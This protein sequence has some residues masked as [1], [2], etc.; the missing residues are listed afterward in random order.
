MGGYLGY[1]R[2]LN[3]VGFFSRA[4]A[5]HSLR[6]QITMTY[7]ELE[8]AL[9]SAFELCATT[10]SALTS[11]QKQILLQVMSALVEEVSILPKSKPDNSDADDAGNDSAGACNPLDE[12]TLAQRQALLE[13]VQEQEQQGRSWKVQLLNDWLA[14]VD[15]GPVQF[16]RESYG[17]KWLDQVAPIHVAQYVETAVTLEVGDRI[18]ISNSLWEW[19][20]DTGP[21]SREWFV[22]TV[23]GLT[24]VAGS[25]EQAVNSQD[26]PSQDEPVSSTTCSVRFE[27]GLEYDIQGVYEWNRY[28]WRKEGDER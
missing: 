17:L 10:G 23:I 11:Q 6:E 27:N 20:Q 4:I 8:A 14:G 26:E 18:E 13:F 15:S 5:L 9:K 1:W 28:S 21:C 22:C 12:L 19:V 25:N 7:A 2:S 3:F 24:Q 16:L